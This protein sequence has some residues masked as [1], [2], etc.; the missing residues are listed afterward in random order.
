MRT[1]RD[2]LEW[3]EHGTKLFTAQV[4]ELDDQEMA[5][6]SALPGWTR[7]HLVAHVAANADALGNLVHWAETGERTPMY[8]SA[9]QRNADI[10]AGA[11][12][13]ASQLTAWMNRATHALAVAMNDLTEEQWRAEVV[14]AQGR[15][16]PATEI[17]WLRAREVCVHAVDLGTGLTFADL[18]DEFLTAL[19]MD[20]QAKRG[21]VEVPGGPLPEVAAYLAGRSHSLVD[22]PD[23]GPWL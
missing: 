18:T 1:H 20:I 22:V 4:A 23:I 8:S 19:V 6:P 9:E 2:S 11:K 5:E 12:L 10:E 3:V 16:V 21:L 17:P 14:T 13:S 15:T 7:K